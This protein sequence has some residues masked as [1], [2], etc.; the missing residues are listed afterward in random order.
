MIHYKIYTV[1]Y[2]SFNIHSKMQIIPLKLHI[3]YIPYAIHYMIYTLYFT[4]SF[5][6]LIS[7]VFC[8]Q[9]RPPK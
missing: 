5:Y 4:L 7:F 2:I 9:P 6:P 3:Q 8:I 1:N